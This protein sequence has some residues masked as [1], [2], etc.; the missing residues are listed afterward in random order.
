MDP[1]YGHPLDR[2]PKKG[3]Q[4]DGLDDAYLVIPTNLCSESGACIPSSGGKDG[5]KGDARSDYYAH[6]AHHYLHS[7]HRVGGKESMM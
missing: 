3:V 6:D 2:G 7:S 1:N 4:N 5:D